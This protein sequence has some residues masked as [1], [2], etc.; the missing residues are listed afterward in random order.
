MS[1]IILFAVALNAESVSGDSPL[2]SDYDE[3]SDD[4]KFADELAEENDEP[5]GH[6]VFE[7]EVT[8]HLDTVK[9]SK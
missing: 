3:A 7:V 8:L 5:S 4:A 6:K 2:S 1:R 9:E